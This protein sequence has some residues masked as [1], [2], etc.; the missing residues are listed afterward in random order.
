MLKKIVG[1][2]YFMEWIPEKVLQSYVVENFF[3][4][5]EVFQKLFEQEIDYV[6]YNKSID[7]YPDLFFVL[8]DKREIP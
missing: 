2:Q 3:E 7:R 8:K 1:R 6:R 5:Q 4:F